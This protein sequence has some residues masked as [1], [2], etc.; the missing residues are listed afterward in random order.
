MLFLLLLSIP[1]IS[2]CGS[3][4]TA[5]GPDMILVKGGKFRMGGNVNKDESP[6]HEVRITSFRLGMY[7]VTV[8]EFRK[9]INSTRYKTDADKEGYSYVF[10]GKFHI[11]NGVNWECDPA[12][13][14]RRPNQENYPVI[15]VSWDDAVAYCGWLSQ[16]THKHYRLPTEAEW[17]YAARGGDRQEPYTYSGSDD[18]G[19][20][21]WYEDNSRWTDHPVG[22]KKPNSLG[23]YDMSGN[24]WEWCQDRYG[25][26]YYSES[27]Q[28]DPV[29]PL[30]GVYRVLRGGSWNYGAIR[31]RVACRD[32]SGEANCGYYNCGFRLAADQ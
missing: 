20:V 30:E 7:E 3:I 11:K 23:I 6:I 10:D 1:V 4:N 14:K 17:E 19:S 2:G 13:G 5:N 18:L 29:G 15:H 12:G 32:G 24:A 16:Q 31:S 25:A 8:G 27:P 9:F 26:T 21:A 28:Q 22:K